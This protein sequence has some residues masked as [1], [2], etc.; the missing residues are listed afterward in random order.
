MKCRMDL[1]SRHPLDRN[2]LY[3][4]QRNFILATVV[5]L[6][7]PGRFVIGELLRGFQRSLV[8][9]IRGDTSRAKGVVTDP[10]LDAGGP[11]APLDHPVGVLLP[12]G[13]A[14]ERAALVGRRL[15]QWRIRIAGYA[16]VGDV[17]IEVLFEIVVTGNLVLL[18]AFFVQAYPSPAAL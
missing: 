4:V 1:P 15:E 5:E 13:V 11:G 17:F 16:G 2:L 6:G 10:G 9:Q 12:H 8:L 18:A 14:G 7:R 3:L